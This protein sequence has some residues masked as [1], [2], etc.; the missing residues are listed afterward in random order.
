MKKFPRSIN[1]INP[2]LMRLTPTNHERCSPYDRQSSRTNFN[3]TVT[4][5]I[6]V[7]QNLK[8]RVETASPY[9]GHTSRTFFARLLDPTSGLRGH[10]SR[11]PKILPWLRLTLLTTLG[12]WGVP[13]GRPRLVD[14]SRS[15]PTY[16][17]GECVYVCCW[18]TTPRWEV[19]RLYQCLRL[20][21]CGTKPQ[22]SKNHHF[23][24][25]SSWEPQCHHDIIMRTPRITGKPKFSCSRGL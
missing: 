3:A 8:R 21:S 15:T 19:T 16:Y 22:R 23:V 2:T 4:S 25:T 14:A 12:L 13:S 5:Y 7:T 24:T 1:V 9:E 6:W 18:F 17:L 20:C 10:T 11:L